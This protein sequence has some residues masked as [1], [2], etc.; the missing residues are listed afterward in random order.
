[1][2]SSVGLCFFPSR[3]TTKTAALRSN[4]APHACVSTPPTNLKSDIKKKTRGHLKAT[5]PP[6]IGSPLQSLDIFDLLYPQRL[7]LS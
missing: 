3:H 5:K 4:V 2:V 7:K 6:N 1:M